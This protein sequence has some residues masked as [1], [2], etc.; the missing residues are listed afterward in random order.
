[1][2]SIDRNGISA[3]SLGIR[4]GHRDGISEGSKVSTSYESPPF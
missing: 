4:A 3:T 2:T 1:M